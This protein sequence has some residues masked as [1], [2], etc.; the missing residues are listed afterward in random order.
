MA[1]A[2]TLL[3][4]LV[5]PGPPG[6]NRYG[7]DPKGPEGSKGGR[8]YCSSCGA[9][10]DDDTRF[11]QSCGEAMAESE[12]DAAEVRPAFRSPGTR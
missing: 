9:E 7:P 6:P 12:P 1:C 11:C 10:N 4:V 5:L 3:I 2:I 8:M